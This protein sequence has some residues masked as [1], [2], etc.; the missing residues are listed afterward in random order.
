MEHKLTVLHLTSWP[1]FNNNQVIIPFFHEQISALSDC[2]NV[3]YLSTEFA[4]ISN[5]LRLFVSK[6]WI[7][8]ISNE[9]WKGK[10]VVTYHCILPR[11][12]TRI[13]HNSLWQDYRLAGMLLGRRLMKFIGKEIDLVH[14]HTILPLGGFAMGL[15]RSL[16]IPFVLQEHSAPFEMHTDTYKKALGVQKII[17]CASII[18]P[19]G[20]DLKRRLQEYCQDDQQKICLV[21]NWVRTDIFGPVNVRQVPDTTSKELILVSVCSSM[22]TKRHDLMFA[23]VRS[24]CD[25]GYQVKLR[26][27]GITS[28]E[29]EINELIEKFQVSD[30]V[31]VH[32]RLTKEQLNAAFS[33]AHI[34]LCTSDVETFG[35]APAEAICCGIPVVTWPC[36]GPEFYI[37]RNNGIV[38][39]DQTV[40]SFVDGIEEVY[41]Q[42]NHYLPDDMWEDMNRKFSK[43]A[44]INNILN[45]YDRI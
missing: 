3:F 26:L 21:P 31:E 22:P 9:N 42:L 1:I 35:L 33:K 2:S 36:G 13:T 11:I 37:S 4:N 5:W 41:H 8:Q 29:F 25:K 6:K 44:Y 18:L 27:Y 28:R 23:V 10:N 17:N 19:V 14:L 40:D 12:S 34:Y 16:S 24:L 39:A 30:L 45:V 32:G 15:K 7:L 43:E 38:V 20:E